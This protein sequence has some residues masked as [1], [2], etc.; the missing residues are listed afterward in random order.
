MREDIPC[1]TTYVY[2]TDEGVYL[3]V[4]FSS[5]HL[6]AEEAEGGGEAGHVAEPAAAGLGAE[7]AE[8]VEGEEGGGGE[9]LQGCGPG[10]RDVGAELAH[11]GA[12][13]L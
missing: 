7:L 13:Q 8:L 11:R 9:D 10:H 2:G 12:V 4:G 5:D 1:G 6:G 3:Q